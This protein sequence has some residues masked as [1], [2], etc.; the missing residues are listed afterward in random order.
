[1][2]IRALQTFAEIARSASIRQAARRAN[3]VPM[4]ISRQIDHLEYFFQAELIDRAASGIRL[5]DAGRILAERAQRLVAEISCIR[6]EI[7]D[8]RGLKRG[9]V[10]VIAGGAVVAGLLVPVLCD[11]NLRYPGLRFLV[12]TASTRAVV[13]AIE[14]GTADVGVTL[15]SPATAHNLICHQARIDHAVIVSPKHALSSLKEATLKQVSEHP[16]ALPDGTFGV[17]QDLDR[18]ARS[19]SI[20]L[21]PVFTTGALDVQKELAVRGAAALILP[22]LCCRAEIAANQLKAIPLAACSTITTSLD[23]YRMPN[24]PTPFAA[25]ALLDAVADYM[26]TLH[27]SGA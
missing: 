23:L 27:S 2:Q 6:A 18:V 21:D 10:S 26:T 25:Q 13:A 1:M 3:T 19:T 8:L 14:N 20:R 9:H 16:M 4:A 12:E 17:R 5:T 24:R 22:P 11:L 7:D 15:F